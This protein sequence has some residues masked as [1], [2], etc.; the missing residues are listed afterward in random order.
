MPGEK[1]VFTVEKMLVPLGVKKL[2]RSVEKL[3][4]RPTPATIELNLICRKTW[5]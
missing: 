5:L 1:V 2:I 3:G 4:S